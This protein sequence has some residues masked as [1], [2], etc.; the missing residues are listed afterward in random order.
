MSGMTKG[1]FKL[2]ARLVKMGTCVEGMHC[3]G[4]GS[5]R[6][7]F[8]AGCQSGKRWDVACSVKALCLGL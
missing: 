6:H 1:E 7:G 5:T 8:A 2:P 4:R 3:R